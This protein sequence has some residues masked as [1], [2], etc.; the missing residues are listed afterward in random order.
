MCVPAKLNSRAVFTISFTFVR[1]FI[2]E[3]QE[4]C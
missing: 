2:V 1:Y 3:G 4:T